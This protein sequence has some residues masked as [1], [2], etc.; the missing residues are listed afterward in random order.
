MDFKNKSVLVVG[1]GI[2]GKGAVSL[3][4]ELGAKIYLYDANSDN[5]KEELI[6]QLNI[7]K[8]SNVF[9][10]EF[11]ITV[12]NDIEYLVLSPGISIDSPFIIQAKKLGVK[13]IG[14]I[15]LA[16]AL[17]KGKIIAITG[18]NGKTT[19]TAL[20]GAIMK[21][22]QENVFVVGNIGTSFAST[23]LNTTKDSITVAEIS[24]FQLETID[25]FKPNVSAVL[26][27][28][29]DHLNRH[30]TMLNYLDVKMSIV[31]N[32]DQNDVCV[33]NLED[34]YIK[35]Y[36][37]NINTRVM[38]FSSK[39]KVENGIYLEEG[40]I[41]L[42]REGKTDLFCKT[43]ELKLIGIHNYE[44]VMAA[45]AIALSI[46]VPEHI[47]KE[48]IVNF[49]SVEHRIEY[50]TSKDNIVY[51][52][53]SKGTNPDASIKAINAMPTQTVL[54]AGGYDKG[55]NY[56][57]W[58]NSFGEKIKCLVLIG[59][60]KFNIAEAAKRNGYTNI[61]FAETLEQAVKMAA[62]AAIPGESVLLSPACAS[63]GM[64]KDYEQRGRM[65]KEY[66]NRI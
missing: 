46:G 38:F 43:S 64:F 36:S 61:L 2:S 9:L 13:V 23:V 33:L 29:P 35:N 34:E 65:F 55:A 14:E 47:I 45:I 4:K 24:S 12:L 21:N 39:N 25:K 50:V 57:E 60:T 31:K 48:T 54:I 27:V 32:Q 66:V 20:V 11:P 15:E 22:F 42:N 26:N 63:W 41:L 8:S 58:V 49:E 28:T 56:D 3:L 53:D 1:L 59:E 17:C 37:K 18:T 16:Y 40:K 19:T 51:Y 52:N 7:A 30:H 5:D 62:N 44:N 6:K 10:G